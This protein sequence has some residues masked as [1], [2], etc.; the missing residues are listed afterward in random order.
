MRFDLLLLQ[1][2]PRILMAGIAQHPRGVSGEF[3]FEDAWCLHL[4]TYH[5]E[6]QV[7][8]ER[9]AIAPGHCSLQAPGTR[10]IYHFHE[11][12]CRHAYCHFRVPSGEGGPVARLPAMQDLGSRFGGLYHTLESAIRF[13]TTS[14]RRGDARLYDFLFTLADLAL[15]EQS[16]HRHPVMQ[17]LLEWIDL[18]LAERFTAA[19]I[20]REFG[21]S[22]NYLNRLFQAELGRTLAAH[23]RGRRAAWATQLPS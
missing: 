10:Q 2:C 6:L 5:G 16:P 15:Q 23:V 1:D 18:H 3:H 20:C 4:Y 9:Y 8:D 22:H 14:P 21:Y 17:P 12:L 19:R 13:R 11:A 7:D